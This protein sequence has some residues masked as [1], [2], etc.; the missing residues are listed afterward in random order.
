MVQ[1]LIAGAIIMPYVV[2]NVVQVYYIVLRWGLRLVQIET[3]SE[4][5]NDRCVLLIFLL[6]FRDVGE[7]LP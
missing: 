5:D 2:F 6:K 3:F 1:V 7:Y 4:L